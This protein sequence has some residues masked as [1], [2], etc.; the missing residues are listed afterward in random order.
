M[1]KED[2]FEN[3]KDADISDLSDQITQMQLFFDELSVPILKKAVR[4][5]AK[6]LRHFPREA[7]L[8]GDDSKLN[9]FD[10]ICVMEQEGTID[11]YMVVRSTIESCCKSA[12]DE[13]SS[14][15]KFILNHKSNSESQEGAEFIT[16]AF[17]T[18][19]LN[20]ETKRIQD[21]YEQRNYFD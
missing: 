3:M 1:I 19:V 21:A 7:N 4:H 10:E 18:Y 17:F 8:F 5:V 14:N 13:L 6:Q 16:Q 2:Q 9:F 20:Y 12:Y 11:D 15:G